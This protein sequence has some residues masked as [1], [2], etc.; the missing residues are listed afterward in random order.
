MEDKPCKLLI[1]MRGKQT[2]IRRILQEAEL[3][4]ITNDVEDGCVN[5]QRLR[6]I[7]ESYD[8]T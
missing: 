7:C 3:G 2:Y 1:I 6:I 8:E 4:E 5:H